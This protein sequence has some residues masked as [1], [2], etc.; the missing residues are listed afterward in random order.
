MIKRALIALVMWV[1]CFHSLAQDIKITLE[2]PDNILIDKIVN[3]AVD[4]QS[5]YEVASVYGKIGDREATLV[6]NLESNLFEGTLSLEGLEQ[7]TL[8]LEITAKDVFDTEIS[9]EFTRVY[10]TP[11]ILNVIEPIHASVARPMVRIK[12]SCVEEDDKPCEIIVTVDPETPFSQEIVKANAIDTVIDYSLNQDAK[13]VRGNINQLWISAVDSR[14]QKVSVNQ[15]IYYEPSPYLKEVSSAQFTIF[16]W[17]GSKMLTGDIANDNWVRQINIIDSEDTVEIPFEGELQKMFLTSQRAIIKGNRNDDNFDELYEWKDGELKLLDT[18]PVENID[19]QGEYVIWESGLTDDYK[20]NLRNVATE[21]NVVISQ[22]P[23][24]QDFYVAANGVAVYNAGAPDYEV[25][26]F[27]D[28][29]S[30]PLTSDN[31]EEVWNQDPITD[32]A[33]FVYTKTKDCCDNPTYAIALHDGNDETIIREFEE[34]PADKQINN[35]FIA[36]SKAGNTQQSQVWLW[37]PDGNASQV[38]FFGK[39][40]LIELLN[41][42]GDIMLHHDEKRYLADSDGEI[43]AIS[44]ANIGKSFWEND[45]WYLSIGRTLFEV[46]TTV[47]L[48]TIGDISKTVDESNS[49]KFYTSEFTEAFEGQGTLV[50]IKI[51]SLPENG[52]LKYNDNPI[53]VPFEIFKGQEQ[54]LTYVPS[55][56]A[57]DSFSWNASNGLAYAASDAKVLLTPEVTGISD[58]LEEESISFSPN[59]TD[60]LLSIS[61]NKFTARDSKVRVINLMGMVIW[62]KEIENQSDK[63]NIDLSTLKSGIYIVQYIYDSQVMGR[64][65]IKY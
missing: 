13:W 14:E 61:L 34:I 37:K 45:T 35:G 60:G 36:Y 48:H 40:S 56:F 41:D 59:P 30:N 10:D 1:N 9:E 6:F 39:N 55:T 33:S 63:V 32:G 46:D 47:S 5:T 11:P 43:R 51:T 42:Q 23:N 4:I 17:N 58:D 53:E 25:Y 19:H 20:L 31:A 38:T 22:N 49:V 21:S 3:I 18:L 16:D 8:V 28:G 24:I 26:S 27:K 12:A 29:M 65:V 52:T 50:K 7:D 44:A 54:Y 15:T 64:K 57:E 2:E 62:E